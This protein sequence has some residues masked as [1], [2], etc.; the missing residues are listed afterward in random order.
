MT[1]LTSLCWLLIADKIPTG[2][3][4]LAYLTKMMEPS[5]DYNSHYHYAQQT[6]SHLAQSQVPTV[7]VIMQNSEL[8]FSCE[9]PDVLLVNNKILMIKF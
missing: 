9:I 1:D 3:T 8:F 4:G 7:K 5:L 6:D 2:A